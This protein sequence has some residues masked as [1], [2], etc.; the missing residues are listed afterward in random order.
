MGAV[1]AQGCGV[2]CSSGFDWECAVL[3]VFVYCCEG[4]NKMRHP[5]MRGLHPPVLPTMD[6]ERGA[7]VII[8]IQLL[9]QLPSFYYKHVTQK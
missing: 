5:R 6:T 8:V 3:R 9:R 4:Q 1:P 7:D 2:V